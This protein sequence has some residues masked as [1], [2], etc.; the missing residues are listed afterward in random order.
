M[1][2]L[3]FS[4]FVVFTLVGCKFQNSEKIEQSS[5]NYPKIHYSSTEHNVG[6]PVS[7]VFQN[8]QYS[9]FYNEFE[10]DKSKIVNTYLTTSKDLIH[11]ENVVELKFSSKK[12]NILNKSIVLDSKKHVLSA[13]L[14]ID[15]D[16]TEN[17]D[18]GYFMISE[19]FDQGKSWTES[20]D[21]V[22]FPYPIKNYFNP[23]IVFDK[24]HNKWIL[25]LIDEQV[26][27]FFSS[28]D[29]R[30]WKYESF[31]EKNI[32]YHN[33]IWNKATLFSIDKSNWVLFIDQEFVDPQQGSSVQYF[34]GTFD[35]QRFITPFSIHSHW[36]DYGKDNYFNVVCQGQSEN[37]EPI[38]I[39]WKNNADYV[40]YGSMKPFWG[41]MTMP[42]TLSLVDYS[43][44]KILAAE[45]IGSLNSLL[46]DNIIL[47]N[48]EVT[49][50]LEI[51]HKI[52]FGVSPSILTLSFETS[53]KTRMTFPLS[54]GVQFENRLGEKLIVGYDTFKEWFFIDRNHLNS[55]TKNSQF[56]GKDLMPCH[57]A[58]SVM[59][60]KIILDDSSIELFTEK[61]K[62]V[63]TNNFNAQN[64]FDKVTIFA[65]NGMIKLK[66]FSIYSLK[67]IADN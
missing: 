25:T 24:I 63:M 16:K 17:N 55:V 4:F 49:E 5:L 7:L 37:T 47:M 44:E 65:E 33:N 27:K 32:Q 64:K 67:V 21:K 61:G 28:S 29:L 15:P 57:H 8:G 26:V 46:L 66:E 18:N 9:L 60:I 50:N 6:A 19:S 23:T 11:W 42:R 38:V 43:G 12:I 59:E 20:T 2:N 13:M 39:G 22:K 1:K 41:S 3:L 54:F 31:F 58:D 14:M 10:S 62:L 56:K 52:P 40:F 30:E 53:E 36:L 35:D 48:L 34:V 45:P 51:S